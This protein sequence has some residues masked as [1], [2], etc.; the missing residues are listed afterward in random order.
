M[1]NGRWKFDLVEEKEDLPVPWR[2]PPPVPQPPPGAGSVAA[3]F[4]AIDLVSRRGPGTLGW[5]ISFR[6]DP[7]AFLLDSMSDAIRVWAA[8]GELIYG[9]R[10]AAEFEVEACHETPLE[11]F[12]KEGRRYERRCLRCRFG[13]TERIVEVIHEIRE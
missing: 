10:A 1:A 2:P 5:T 8:A 6:H 13:E 4:E 11:L 7:I 9:N 12:T 3:L